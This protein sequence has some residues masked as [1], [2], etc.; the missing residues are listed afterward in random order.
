MN[1]KKKRT[2]REEFQLNGII[3]IFT[4]IIAAAEATFWYIYYMY[5]RPLALA[6]PE[7]SMPI[8]F[9]AFFAI[10]LF[11]VVYALRRMKERPNRK[12]K[13]TLPVTARL[14]GMT[15]GLKYPILDFG[16]FQ[17]V[18]REK[19]DISKYK[20][21]KEI[22]V[23]L[24]P[25]GTEAYLADDKEAVRSDRFFLIMG[26]II[27]ACQTYVAFYFMKSVGVF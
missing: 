8:V 3:W 27:L 6:N 17:L 21:T 25:D 19:I 2:A 4:F 23:F 15:A 24:D 5:I 12:A 26:L 7:V 18:M 16:H 11:S 10:G 14:C 20:E 9:I 1:N 13:C 22:D